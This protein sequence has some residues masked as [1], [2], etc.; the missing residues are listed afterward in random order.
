[1]LTKLHRDTK[2]ES[3]IVTL[4]NVASVPSGNPKRLRMFCV[5]LFN[6]WGV[7]MSRTHTVR[8]CV[9]CALGRLVA[10]TLCLC[11]SASVRKVS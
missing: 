10:R 7:G 2:I 5:E 4:D 1:M 11:S 8:L 6:E 9:G 3:A